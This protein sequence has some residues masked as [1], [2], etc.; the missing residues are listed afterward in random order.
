MT[1]DAEDAQSSL[2][3]EPNGSVMKHQVERLCMYYDV[4]QQRRIQRKKDPDAVSAVNTA[5]YGNLSG[6]YMPGR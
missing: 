1:C 6:Y 3:E 4:G 5:P 2:K